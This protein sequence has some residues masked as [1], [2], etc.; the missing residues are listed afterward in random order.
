MQLTRMGLVRRLT[1]LTP[2]LHDGRG[3]V[4]STMYK[5]MDD[6]GGECRRREGG[7]AASRIDLIV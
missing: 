1:A 2:I 6:H 3:P 7:L 5:S 4:T